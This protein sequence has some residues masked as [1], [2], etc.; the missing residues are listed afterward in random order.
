M[1]KLATLLMLVIV[2]ALIVS[3][4]GAT[5]APSGGGQPAASDKTPAA[6]ATRPPAVKATAKPAVI[7][8]P[9]DTATRSASATDLLELKDVTEGLSALSSYESTFAMSFK[10][11]DSGQPK[12]WTWTITE[13]FVKNPPAKRSTMSGIGTDVSGQ[14]TS[15]ET[16]EVNG[17]TYSKFG[18]ICA[19][20]DAS[21]APTANTGFTPSSVIGDIKTAQLL[22]TDTINGV[23]AQHFA[24][25]MAGLTALGAYT[26]GKSE[27]WI[28]QPGNFV[29]KYSFEAIGKDTF[30]GGGASAEGTI[31][32]AYEIKSAN[33]PIVIEPPKDC[34]GAPA[35]IPMMADAT[36][37][38]AFGTMT[39]YTSVTAFD[40]VVKFYQTE[41]VAKGWAAQDGGMSADGFATLMFIKDTRTASVTIT[42]DTEKNVTSVLISV[43]APQ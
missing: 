25:D 43:E 15:I 18:D 35:D 32:W 6:T 23:P 19:A 14:N 16:I 29:V 21:E 9:A 11:T 8:P 2:T 26:N 42:A 27:V 40:T 12:E 31:K 28:A 17:K 10:G 41:M 5:P 39:T 3:A 1:K 4:C 30:F 36:N 7:Q 13:Q 20:S 22:G 34:G 38:A 37:Q 24:V 33:Q